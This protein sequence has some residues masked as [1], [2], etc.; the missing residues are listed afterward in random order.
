MKTTDQDLRDTVTT[1]ILSGTLS[2]GE[3]VVGVSEGRS[4]RGRLLWVAV[5]SERFYGTEPDRHGGTELYHYFVGGAING[6]PQPDR[7]EGLPTHGFPAAQ[8]LS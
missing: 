1:R 2:A 3:L 5:W 4:P 8:L 6:T 7:G